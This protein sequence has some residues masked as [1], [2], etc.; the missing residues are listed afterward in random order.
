MHMDLYVMFMDMYCNLKINAWLDTMAFRILLRLPHVQTKLVQ[1]ITGNVAIFWI[2]DICPQRYATADFDL[3][4][5]WDPSSSQSLA[6]FV[7]TIWNSSPLRK[8]LLQVIQIGLRTHAT[9]C[10][11]R[12]KMLGSV[13]NKAIYQIR[14]NQLNSRPTPKVAAAV[15]ILHRMRIPTSISQHVS[16]VSIDLDLTM[17]V[18]FCSINT[19]GFL[20]MMM[21]SYSNR[22]VT[23]W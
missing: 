12:C 6:G 23:L 22:L 16:E 11:L 14:L 21:Y 10:E 3:W 4:P 17:I 9:F 1:N 19:Q 8:L 5:C 7:M 13:S 15:W 20:V 18:Y 2:W